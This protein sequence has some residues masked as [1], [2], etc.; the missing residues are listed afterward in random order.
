MTD[1]QS[2]VNRSAE[3]DQAF[4]DLVCE[5]SAKLE[6][7]E[8]VDLDAIAVEHPEQ[9][10]RLRKLL[11]TLQA[12]TGHWTFAPGLSQFVELPYLP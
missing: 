4:D 6:A 5:V 7:G 10:D 1:R 12:F 2:V 8:A 11:P 3:V 9:V